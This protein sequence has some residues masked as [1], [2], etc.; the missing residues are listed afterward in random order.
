M[1]FSSLLVGICLGHPDAVIEDAIAAWSQRYEKMSSVEYV[2]EGHVVTTPDF[3]AGLGSGKSVSDEPLRIQIHAKL[4]FHS[5]RAWVMRDEYQWNVQLNAFERK[6][7]ETTVNNGTTR[8]ITLSPQGDK[9][10][11]RVYDEPSKSQSI[12]RI[13]TQP[14]WFNSGIVAVGELRSSLFSLPDYTTHR[15]LRRVP[16]DPE[17]TL[18]RFE[19]KIKPASPGGPSYVLTVDARNGNVILG[20]D[21]R[22]YAGRLTSE[23]RMSYQVVEGVNVAQG[24]ESSA[25]GANGHLLIH[26]AFAVKQFAKNCEFPEETFSMTNDG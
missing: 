13:D 12:L 22:D 15:G 8:V 19:L 10:L 2:A 14:M 23:I 20:L 24:W 9:R 6:R 7:T 5:A 21:E 25:Y 18:G 4:E 11:E 16:D 26:E 3:V 17:K 1:L